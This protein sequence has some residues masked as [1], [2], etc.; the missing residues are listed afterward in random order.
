MDQVRTIALMMAAGK[1]S[2]MKADR[3]KIYLELS[4]KPVLYYAL[5]AYEESEVGEIILVVSPGDEDYVRK[6]IVEK[7]GFAKVTGIVPGGRERF[8]SVYLGIRACPEEEEACLLIHDGARPF[9]RPDQIN[10]CIRETLRYKACAMA[11]P[12][13]DTIR[14]VDDECFSLSTPNRTYVWAMQTPQCLLLS[15]GRK[16]YEAMM[17]SGDKDITDDVMVM[18]R[19][20]GR[21]SKMIPG[22]YDNIKLTTPEDMI[23]G[24]TILSRYLGD[25]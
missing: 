6:E 2:R 25:K 21:R 20:A 1:G 10:L 12:V 19:Y 4:G 22:S 14:I 16:A 24:E 15:E 17:N 9:I 23:I 3:N 13:K 7:Y 5:K 18:E 11:M 8:E